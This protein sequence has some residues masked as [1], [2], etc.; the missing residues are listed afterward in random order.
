[1]VGDELLTGVVRDANLDYLGSRLAEVGLP[2]SAATVVGD[3]R[4]LLAEEIDRA[5]EQSPV[6]IVTGGLGPTQD[7]VTREAAAEALGVPLV[8]SPAAM[9]MVDAF[10]QSLSRPLP[11][12]ARR[13]ALLPEG[14]EPLFN[15]VG[16]APGV[17]WK[18]DGRLLALLPGVPRE[19]Q[20]IF[21]SGVAPLLAPYAGVGSRQRVFR[22]CG[23]REVDLEKM[24]AP[25]VSRHKELRFCFLPQHYL[26]D[27]VMT[28]EAGADEAE[29]KLVRLLGWHLL[30]KGKP[31]LEGVVG[32][33][34]VD[35]N[36]TVAI[37]ESLT[38]GLA[39]DMITDVPGSSRYFWGGV[40]AYSNEAKVSLLAVN[41]ETLR[42]HGA[43]SRE[44]A[45]EMARGGAGFGVTYSLSLTGIAGPE[46]GAPAKPVGLVYVGL[47]APEGTWAYSFL[48]KGDRRTIKEYSASACLNILRLHLLGAPH[49]AALAGASDVWG[50]R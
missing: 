13:E 50:E 26:V 19:L 42:A 2:L 20:A 10:Y 33:L 16:A 43:V 36:A 45:M 29:E 28:G 17:I 38:G 9:Q 40:T 3:A 4:D 30:G 41:P 24:I 34:L 14:A 31:K 44:V 21:E 35:E 6:V 18:G 37:A 15:P 11:H 27:V 32:T 25:V 47:T 48:W 1:M 46:G 12:G 23:V 49:D 22:T 39:T 7:D 5:V 8:H